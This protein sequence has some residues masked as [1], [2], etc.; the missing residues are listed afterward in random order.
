MGFTIVAVTLYALELLIDDTLLSA[1]DDKT[2]TIWSKAKDSSW[3]HTKSIQIG[4][5][6]GTVLQL[7][8]DM[9]LYGGGDNSKQDWRIYMYS[10]SK[11]K[12]TW[13]FEGHTD[14][15]S[16]VVRLDSG[17]LVS[18]SFDNTIRV[19]DI[20]S[21]KHKV[22]QGHNAWVLAVIQVQLR[23]TAYQSLMMFTESKMR[24]L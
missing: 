14:F 15:V 9:I 6:I 11:N 21:M 19:W 23:L 5:P 16:S 10:L 1:S 2:I 8:N 18:S 22:L 4:I 7:S 17:Q 20:A 3:T 12:S 13:D 24:K